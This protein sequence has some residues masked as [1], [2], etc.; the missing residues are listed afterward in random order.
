MVLDKMLK[1]PY[2]IEPYNP[3]WPIKFAQIKEDLMQSFGDKALLIEH[4][5][6]TAMPGMSSKG[7]IDV[8][9]VVDHMEPFEKEKA[10]MVARGYLYGDDY[11]TPNSILIYKEKP[12]LEKEINIHVLVQGDPD[13]DKFIV[14]R[15]YFLAHP[16]RIQMY[17]ELKEKLSKEFPDD[18]PSYRA[19]KQ[20]FLKE[21]LALAQKWKL[22]QNQ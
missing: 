9:V 8:C 10:A 6:S 16:E 7:V 22:E 13:I 2:K 11:F 3:Q 17:K 12:D 15:D 4:V 20:D 1:R 18:Y 14:G 21:T 5:G 19:G